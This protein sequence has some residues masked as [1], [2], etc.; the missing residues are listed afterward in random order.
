[1]PKK[2]GKWR[3]YVDYSDLNK[4]CPKN[5]FPLPHIDQRWSRTAFL[6]GCLLRVQ[7]N[8]HVPTR[9]RDITPNGMYRYKVMLFGLKNVGAT[10]QRMMACLFEPLV[11][12]SMEIYINDMLIKSKIRGN[13]I[14]DVKP[15]DPTRRLDR[16][17]RRGPLNPLICK[18]HFIYSFSIGY[19][20]FV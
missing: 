3:V 16:T 2:N 9:S 12:K 6:Y 10:Y 1:M 14:C 17:R 5:P 13:H 18:T 4:A 7:P 11:G 8:P 20:I 15:L 19:L